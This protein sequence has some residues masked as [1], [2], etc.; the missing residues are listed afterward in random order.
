VP[1]RVTALPRT[2][3]DLRG[4]RCALWIRESTTGQ[5]DNFGPDAQ[6]DQYDRAI[7]RYALIDTG[8]AWAVAASG[9]K[10]AWR[11]EAWADMIAAAEGGLFDVLVAGYASRFSRNLQQILNAVNDHLH[12]SGVVVLFADERL[13]SSDPDHWDQFHREALEAESYSRKLSKRVTEGYAA[14]RRRL[15]VPGGNRVPFGTLREGHPSRLL[16]DDEKL[17]LVRRAYDLSAAGL[18]DR[19]AA[20]QVGLRLTHVRE[21]L[22]NPFYRGVLRTGERSALGPLVDPQQWDQVQALR[23]RYSRRHRGSVRRRQYALSGLLVCGACGRRLTGH[24]GR[25][26]HVD[27]CAAFKSAAPRSKR[28]FSRNYDGRLRGESYPAAWYDDMVAA[29]L[30][31]VAASGKL[32]ADS[33]PKAVAPDDPRLDDFTRAR[34][35]RD[36]QL[37]IGRY[38]RD[39]DIAELQATM[40]RLDTEEARAQELVT[41]EVSPESVR[42]YLAN[43]S[44]LWEDTEPEG[45]RAIAEA[46]FDRIEAIGLD[47][48]VHPSA[49]AERYGWSEAFGSEPL[50]CS[51]SHSGRGE[52][53]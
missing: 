39:R 5:L 24:V 28:T 25:Y 37:A 7:A 33:M 8:L 2:L 14:K 49:E 4:R 38:V 35:E 51:I 17:A 46:T 52:R 42:Y 9:W 27:A 53:I 36:R 16:V 20:A 11:T 34:I 6:R 29:A 23:A 50:M 44:K 47:L 40:A 26:R 48:V 31:R 43:P 32:L 12:P 30:R 45:R 21:I 10:T 1:R 18:S 3:D 41:V 15:G 22:T 13:L 19:E